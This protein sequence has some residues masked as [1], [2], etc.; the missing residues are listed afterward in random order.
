MTATFVILNESMASRHEA[1]AQRGGGGGFF[2]NFRDNFDDFDDGGRDSGGRRGGGGFGRDR[3][4][5][6]GDYGLEDLSPRERREMIREETEG[7]N[8]FE[9]GRI[10]QEF[11]KEL[12][13]GR[14]LDQFDR[15]AE[16]L[17]ELYDRGRI[18][19]EDYYRRLGET[20]ERAYRNNGLGGSIFSVNEAEKDLNSA[21]NSLNAAMR[22][23]EIDR[24][25]RDDL[26]DQIRGN[27]FNSAGTAMS[28]EELRLRRAAA[29]DWSRGDFSDIGINA[30]QIYEDL[31]TIL[32]RQELTPEEK[33]WRRET[34]DY[35]HDHEGELDGA[36]ID[37][38]QT[39]VKEGDQPLQAEKGRI[40]RSNPVLGE[41]QSVDAASSERLAKTIMQQVR[42]DVARLQKGLPEGCRVE[43]AL[44]LLETLKE[45]GD[46]SLVDN[47]QGAIVD[48]DIRRFERNA[49]ALGVPKQEIQR[50]LVGISLENLQDNLEDDAPVAEIR[51]V[52]AP[53]VSRIEDAG[54]DEEFSIAFLDWLRFIP[55]LLQSREEIRAGKPGTGKPAW[56]NG[57]VKIV[58]DPYLPPGEVRYLSTSM[59]VTGI[60]PT[61]GIGLGTG[62]KFNASGLPVFTNASSAAGDDSGIQKIVL[63]NPDDVKTAVRYKLTCKQMM[64]PPNNPAQAKPQTR[65]E[66]E[67][68]LAPGKGHK[69]D[70]LW[71]DARCWY[72]IEC[73]G[74]GGQKSSRYL[75]D[76]K[77]GTNPTYTFKVNDDVVTL[78]RQTESIV[79]DNTLNARPFHFLLGDEHQTVRPGAKMF[80]D[81]EV[82]LKYANNART[83][84]AETKTAATAKTPAKPAAETNEHIKI[85][86]LHDGETGLIGVNDKGNWEIRTQG[87]ML[88]ADH[89]YVDLP[90]PKLGG[91]AE[92]TEIA[93]T[94]PAPA[95]GN[96]YVVAVGISKYRNADDFPALT[97]ADKDAKVLSDV[98][99]Q[100]KELFNDVKTFVLT[101]E[102]ATALKIRMQ[103]ASLKR[104]VTKNDTVALIF[105]GHGVVEKDNYY[106]CPQ[107]ATMKG[108][109]K[110]GISC[111]ELRQ[112]T[113]D[114]AAR[115]VFVMLDSCKSGGATNT[116]RQEGF[117]EQIQQYGASGV[118]VFASSTDTETSQENE[119]WG[120]GALTKAFLDTLADVTLDKNRDSIVQVAELD[121]GLTEGVKKLTDGGQHVQSAEMGRIIRNLA[122]VKYNAEQ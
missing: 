4:D 91:I 102:E 76:P 107:D 115:N 116:F 14:A 11:D 70:L 50:I 61:T 24:W 53:M 85:L 25:E 87:E 57:N 111:N 90:L 3:D 59:L 113:S 46:K 35:Y 54:F 95:R 41:P 101:N 56:P 73:L 2:D 43:D 97:F 30:E 121:I 65:W 42:D 7:L 23:G 74:I 78:G 88:V 20:R 96:L 13:E 26:L 15:D 92:Q 66:K 60:D 89:R 106:F 36:Q 94:A 47:L 28:P 29:R 100:Q 19:D 72:V 16:K 81:T 44:A 98:L 82:T 104:E 119:S 83:D 39:W 117:E 118:V 108:L 22:R 77:R 51:K 93:A 122:L 5:D 45:N 6:D 40:P 34:L 120:H 17:D 27:L 79:L 75:L 8:I 68:S 62:D 110:L 33:R 84:E 52:T 38:L 32:E 114:L 37:V 105:A 67:Y 31:G 48:R 58:Y 80:F 86:T 10:R 69:W 55:D 18:S 49:E 12:R 64:A 63:R 103:L 99:Q 71:S 112:I 1:F 109:R 9:K 21:K